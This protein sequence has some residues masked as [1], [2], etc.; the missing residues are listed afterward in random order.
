[1]ANSEELQQ[2]IG[3]GNVTFAKE[4]MERRR[5]SPVH[6]SGDAVQAQLKAKGGTGVVQMVDPKLGF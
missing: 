6:V 2:A 5:G 3:L 4:E 1:M